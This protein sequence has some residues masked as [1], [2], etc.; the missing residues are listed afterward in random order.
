MKNILII[1]GAAKF[2][3]ISKAQLNATLTQFAQNFLETKG[4]KL[5]V[6]HV[7]NGYD[8][9]EEVEKYLWADVIIYQMPGW[10]MG[11]P[12][13][14][15]KY[16]D[17]VFSAGHGKLY[18]SDGRTRKDL[19]RQY[20]S[21]GL[22]HNKKYMLSLTWNAPIQAFNLPDQFFEGVGADG[23]YFSFHKAN[24]FLGMK[25]LETF[26]INDVI[27]NSNLPK[28]LSQYEHHLNNVFC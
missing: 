27:K 28:Y 24:Q 2:G 5:K 3:K 26:M 19:S 18:E 7:E 11:L 15:K 9:E 10:W 17:E 23:V 21:A 20:G 12:W 1:N 16:I 25:A 8:V 13:I 4:N 22:S 6:T 14:L